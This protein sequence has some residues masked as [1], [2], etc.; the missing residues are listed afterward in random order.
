M[1]TF[2]QLS[3]EQ[4]KTLFGGEDTTNGYICGWERPDALHCYVD[5]C[6]HDLTPPTC[7]VAAQL[8]ACDQ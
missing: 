2:K 7:H 6:Y 5:I 8:S 4:M 3:R 1:G